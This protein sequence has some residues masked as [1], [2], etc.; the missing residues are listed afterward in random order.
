M[1]DLAG[2][3]ALVTGAS[4]GLG[5]RAALILA[6]AGA[7]VVAVARRR[8]ALDDLATEAP[9]GRIAARPHDLSDRAALPDLARDCAAPF[10]PPDI[11][12]HA[13]GLNTRET[14]DV[15]TPEGWDAT[16]HLNLAVP[17]FL[18]QHLVAGMRAKGWGR[19]VTFASLQTTRAFP[20][21]LSYGASKGGI[22]QLTRAM[23]E[24]WSRDG[25]LANA[26]GPGFFPTELTEAVFAD[27]DRAA[28]NAAQTCIGRNGTPEDID[29]PLLFLCSEACGYVTG[30]VLMVD[31]G[32]TAK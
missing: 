3:V 12:V 30:Q 2:H 18:S 10:G 21:G 7:R 15:V 19:I 14:A 22:A 27:P 16:L 4:S 6:R 32:F 24:A 5:R 20:G 23:A 1:I 31:G 29:G 8:D 26:I 9:E 25:I 13:A 17:F 28:R 11:L